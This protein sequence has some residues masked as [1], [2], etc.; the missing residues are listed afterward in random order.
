MKEEFPEILRRNFVVENENVT[1]KS[2]G[3]LRIRY[4]TK[5]VVS[6]IMHE[7]TAVTPKPETVLYK[8][9]LIKAVGTE[10]A[11]KRIELLI[12]SS[13]GG[14]DS[15]RSELRCTYGSGHQ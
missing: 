6:R 13:N 15:A 5:A 4:M 9:D 7:G 14:G 12:G 11:L 8:D 2:I 3:E 10:E 1:G